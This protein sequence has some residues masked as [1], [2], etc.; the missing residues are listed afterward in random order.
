MD[1]SLAE[2]KAAI[3]GKLLA[4]GAYEPLWK[5][6]HR[7]IID[8]DDLANHSRKALMTV[9]DWSTLIAGFTDK[10]NHFLKKAPYDAVVSHNLMIEADYD[11]DNTSYR[12]IFVVGHQETEEQRIERVYLAEKY[13]KE[14][15]AKK[16]AK[17]AADKKVDAELELEALMLRAQKDKKLR[18]KLLEKVAQLG[19]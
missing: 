6:L 4:K 17:K 1:L 8:L 5:E 13:F 16:A 18:A 9:L 14:E 15:R 11:Y 10:L 2:K 7:E 3:N 12:L 19:D